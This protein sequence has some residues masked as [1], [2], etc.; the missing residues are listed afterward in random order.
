MELY[1]TDF[2][3]ERAARQNLA[4][5]KDVLAQQVRLL[6]RQMENLQSSRPS[7]AASGPVS[8][9]ASVPEATLTQLECPKCRFAFTTMD[10]LNNHLDICLSQ[11]MFP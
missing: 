8:T 3:A 4:G 10:S 9:S 5:E 2:E 7:S 11:H 1:Q 6:K